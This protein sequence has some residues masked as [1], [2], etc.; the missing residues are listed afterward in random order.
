M[1]QIVESLKA[2]KVVI[3]E[4]VARDGAQAK[5]LLTGEQRVEIARMTSELFRG[6]GHRHLV[7][8]A[9]F[10]SIGKREFEAI[11]ALADQVDTCHLASNGRAM[12]EDVDLCID[13][14]RGARHPR[15]AIVFP[16]GGTLTRSM[17]KK[18]PHELVD[19]GA[20]ILKYALDRSGGIPIDM[21]L[22]GASENEPEFVAEVAN[23]FYE[24]GASTIGFADSIGVFYPFECER[25]IDRLRARVNPEIP[26]ST[27]FHNDLGF[28]SINNIMAMRRDVKLITSSWL[29]LGERNGLLATE[30]LLFMLGY[31]E[32]RI[33]ERTGIST[34]PFTEGIDLKLIYPI[35]KRVSEFTGVPFKITDPIV[36]T[37]INTI[38]T[39]TPFVTPEAF[40]PFDAKKVLGIEQQVFLT[41]LANRR[42]VRKVAQ[43]LGRE[44]ED[45]QVAWL[46]NW[47]KETAFSRGRAVIDKAEF[48]QVIDQ[49]QAQ[50]G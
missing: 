43:E 38:S 15:A 34:R 24:L 45:G 33:E 36:G 12:R 20:D 4:E 31:Q 19:F 26:L 35:A 5:T 29:G 41:Q 18:E 28:A 48:A 22:A 30:Q 27:H 42:V 21:Q 1:D 37:G 17:L 6:H 32:E 39:G 14:V 47:V 16:V 8:A 50:G 7:F 9:G 25:Y 10:P 49:L 13:S 40:Q 2:G 44:L 11:R 3:W 46:L 23:R